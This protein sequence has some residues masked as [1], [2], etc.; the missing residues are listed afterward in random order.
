[1]LKQF[2]FSLLQY[3]I[4][5]SS[6]SNINVLTKIQKQPSKGVLEKKCSKNMQQIYR[7]TPIP[8]C[9][10]VWVFSYKFAAYG[11]DTFF[12]NISGGLLLKILVLKYELV[13]CKNSLLKRYNQLHVY[14]EMSLL[15]KLSIEK[16]IQSIHYLGY[17]WHLEVSTNNDIFIILMTLFWQEMNC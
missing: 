4:P 15:W 10:L 5:L 9:T 13:T 14:H 17:C 6:P 12:K 7:R 3:N 8:K 16:T 2:V 11:W 1:M